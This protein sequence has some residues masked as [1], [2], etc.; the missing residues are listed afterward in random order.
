M[1]KIR[2]RDKQAKEMRRNSGCIV[3]TQRQKKIA[4]SKMMTRD[5]RR[6]RYGE[7]AAARASARIFAAAFKHDHNP[8]AATASKVAALDA[9]CSACCA[10]VS[11]KT[12]ARCAAT[13]G[14]VA[15]TC[16]ATQP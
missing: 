11:P 7:L 2:L 12:R 4:R 6:V 8:P 9:A 16:P 5:D 1:T 3:R 13:A 10:N 15:M 14:S